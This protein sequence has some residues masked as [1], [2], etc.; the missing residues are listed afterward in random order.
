MLWD[1]LKIYLSHRRSHRFISWWPKNISLSARLNID[2]VPFEDLFE[3]GHQ[4]VVTSFLKAS[5]QADGRTDDMGAGTVRS[6][7]H[8]DPWIQR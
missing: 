3:A 1:S 5:V 4:P 2:V 7:G 6:D 8:M